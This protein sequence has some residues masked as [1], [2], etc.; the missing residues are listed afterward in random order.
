MDKYNIVIREQAFPCRGNVIHFM[1]AYDKDAQ[2]GNQGKEFVMITKGRVA[3]K[4]PTWNSLCLELKSQK[5]LSTIK[6]LEDDVQEFAKKLYPSHTFKS[7]LKSF[8]SL[9][10]LVGG[11]AGC[12]CAVTSDRC[13]EEQSRQAD[14]CMQGDLGR[15]NSKDVPYQMGLDRMRRDWRCS[16]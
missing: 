15:S 12:R 11:Q 5:M 6:Q 14:G 7:S 2:D 3:T 8:G 16:N 1:N 4:P 13:H 9:Q 10:E